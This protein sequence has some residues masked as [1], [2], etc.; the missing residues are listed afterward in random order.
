MGSCQAL[1]KRTD[2]CRS[3]GILFAN[4]YACYQGP[5]REGRLEIR[6][7]LIVVESNLMDIE[8]RDVLG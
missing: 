1:S 3:D 5:V 7:T 8:I 4:S 6:R 2:V